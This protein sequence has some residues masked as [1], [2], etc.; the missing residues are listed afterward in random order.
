MSD[1]REKREQAERRLANVERELGIAW[2]M[3]PA[4][5]EMAI[6]RVAD[7]ERQLAQR[8]PQLECSNCHRTYEKVPGMSHYC[9]FPLLI[10]FN[11]DP[12]EWMALVVPIPPVDSTEPGAENTFQRR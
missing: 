10:P 3:G 4:E 12:N 1:E 7:L 2:A 5:Y 6:K 11:A 8:C 9:H